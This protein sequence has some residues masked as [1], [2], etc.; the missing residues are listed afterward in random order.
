M[1]NV[2]R[3][4]RGVDPTKA[5]KRKQPKLTSDDGSSNEV[6]DIDTKRRRKSLHAYTTK[7]KRD[8]EPTSDDDLSSEDSDIDKKNEDEDDDKSSNNGSESDDLSNEDSDIDTKKSSGSSSSEREFNDTLSESKNEDED[9]DKSSN[10]GSES[11]TSGSGSGTV[12]EKPQMFYISNPG[13]KLTP[14]TSANP[15]NEDALKHSGNEGD[16]SQSDKESQSDNDESDEP[17]DDD[18]CVPFSQDIPQSDNDV[19]SS[20]SWKGYDN[21]QMIKPSSYL[22]L[23]CLFVPEKDKLLSQ[24]LSFPTIVGPKVNVRIVQNAR[25]LSP[26]DARENILLSMIKMDCPSSNPVNGDITTTFFAFEKSPDGFNGLGDGVSL[27]SFSGNDKPIGPKTYIARAIKP[28]DIKR[29][30]EFVIGGNYNQDDES[31]LTVENYITEIQAHIPLNG[32]YEDLKFWYD[33]K[34]WTAN[35]WAR[36]DRYDFETGKND[37]EKAKLLKRTIMEQLAHETK[38][39]MSPV[40]GIHRV[41]NLGAAIFGAVPEGSSTGFEIDI[42]KFSSSICG[43]RSGKSWKMAI[44]MDGSH[45]AV[46]VETNTIMNIVSPHPDV[47]LTKQF[48]K[49]MV[50]FSAFKQQ[51]NSN[52]QPHTLNDGIAF[53]LEKLSERFN[54]FEPGHL[55]QDETKEDALSKA[56]KHKYDLESEVSAMR[57]SMEG[58]RMVRKFFEDHAPKISQ[59]ALDELLKDLSSKGKINFYRS[60]NLGGHYITCWV[61]DFSRWLKKSLKEIHDDNHALLSQLVPELRIKELIGLKDDEWISLFKTIR[62]AKSKT[63]EEN[64]AIIP[65][66]QKRNT[67]IDMLAR[68]RMTP[69]LSNYGRTELAEKTVSK[70]YGFQ[71]AMEIVWLIEWAFIDKSSFDAVH[72]LFFNAKPDV[73]RFPQNPGIIGKDQIMRTLTCIIYVITSSVFAS[74]DLWRLGMMDTDGRNYTRV[75]NRMCEQGLDAMLLRHAVKDSTTFF[76]KIGFNP[77]YPPALEFNI[78]PDFKSLVSVKEKGGVVFHAGA[79]ICTDLVW[80]H[81]ITFVAHLAK[82]IRGRGRLRYV[83]VIAC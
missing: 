72:G 32:P 71:H 2:A 81:V 62:K 68:N 22:P 14:L 75:W 54:E 12:V 48:C 45:E 60:K 80:F 47:G 50:E 59:W 67:L 25:V 13:K 21:I 39:A 15:A 26:D 31:A 4:P 57:K 38:I 20:K 79:L 11:D 53:L 83:H 73:M 58:E 41:A 78:C 46:E 3:F 27:E 52:S 1:A 10:N 76:S 82:E 44:M 9:D 37:Q 70:Q 29:A 43:I 34:I 55:F 77:K 35:P 23:F 6:I 64:I 24:D 16:D 61:R 33:S 18:D 69:H 49:D 74:R 63:G 17:T 5:T 42:Q 51:Q 65:G 56:W 28:D 40:D 8:P 36:E 7:R 30:I 19:V 66:L